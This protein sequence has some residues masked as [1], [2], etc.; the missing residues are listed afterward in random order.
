MTQGAAASGQQRKAELIERFL[1][2]V[3]NPADC[4]DTFDRSCLD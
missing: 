3:I 1:D 2:C 4:V